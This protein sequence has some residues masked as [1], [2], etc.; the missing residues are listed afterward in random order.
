MARRGGL[1]ITE[2]AYGALIVAILS[3]GFAVIHY[4]ILPTV[5]TP[6]GHWILY[7]IEAVDL[8]TILAIAMRGL[9]SV[10]HFFLRLAK[11]QQH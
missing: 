11:R 1:E 5:E 2:F 10:L 7:A 4:V 9:Y 3:A 8:L 6:V